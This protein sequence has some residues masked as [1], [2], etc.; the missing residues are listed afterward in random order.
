MSNEEIGLSG[1]DSGQ[2]SDGA[3]DGS[4][5]GYNDDFQ[6]DY[7]RQIS[8]AKPVSQLD[9]ETVGNLIESGRHI[10]A[11]L[12]RNL[13]PFS[14]KESSR[15]L[16]TMLEH[17]TKCHMIRKKKPMR[18]SRR[19]Q[20][21]AYYLYDGNHRFEMLKRFYNN[22]AYIAIHDK[23]TKKMRYAFFS[24][25]GLTK[26]SHEEVFGF[27]KEDA[28]VLD[29]ILAEKIKTAPVTFET[30]EEDMP[31]AEA[32]EAARIAN[33]CRALLPCQIAKYL[34]STPT[35][36]GA[37]LKEISQFG[38]SIEK[39]LVDEVYQCSASV[40][41][42]VY[43]HNLTADFEKVV[44][45]IRYVDKIADIVKKEDSLVHTNLHT[46][47]KTVKPIVEQKLN[48]A[49]DSTNIRISPQNTGDKSV[50][51]FFLIALFLAEANMEADTSLDRG[52]ISQANVTALF[53]TYIEMPG[54]ERGENLRR[55]YHYF[56]HGN[57]PPLK[58]KKNT[59][60]A[61]SAAAAS[62]SA[63][64]V[65]DSDSDEE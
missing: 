20:T 23:R 56:R 11:P 26:H 64:A 32:Y 31:E 19:K 5:D 59:R 24:S 51:S 36:M 60:G 2:D 28:V 49:I 1:S 40:L 45:K 50:V 8:R 12:N 33:E 13:R 39:F 6:G 34:C 10:T 16:K 43:F 62:S 18:S 41:Q 53:K 47:L 65:I 21:F 37:T 15:R 22:D 30:L 4:N 29:P 46:T 44:T 42:L 57:F 48:K 35:K 52:R 55:T 54:S 9:H 25:E 27:S 7:A 61:P 3:G 38:G 63:A 17:R 14:H 58:K